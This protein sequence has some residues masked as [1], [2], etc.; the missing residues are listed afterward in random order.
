MEEEEQTMLLFSLR[1]IAEQLIS[2][3]LLWKSRDYKNIKQFVC[4][5]INSKKPKSIVD[6]YEAEKEKE[7][8]K[9][10]R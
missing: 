3:E 9:E 7:E 6:V 2:D 10:D 5:D 1:I 8:K 4:A